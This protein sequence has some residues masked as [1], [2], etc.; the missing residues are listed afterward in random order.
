MKNTSLS[1][2]ENDCFLSII[3]PCAA[4]IASVNY[5]FAGYLPMAAGMQKIPKGD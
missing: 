2:C 4:K 5:S 1:H 3:V